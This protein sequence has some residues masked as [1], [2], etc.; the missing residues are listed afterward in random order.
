M[1]FLYILECSDG[2]F[3]TGITNDLK[4]R[5]QRHNSA[6]ASKYTRLRLPVVLIY[7]EN[8]ESRSLALKREAQVKRLSRIQK[9]QL[10]RKQ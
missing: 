1:W 6:K 8:L 5:L 2:S 3:Y 9:E 7:S 10:V 4:K